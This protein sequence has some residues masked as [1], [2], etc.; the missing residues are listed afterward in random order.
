MVDDLI[1]NENRNESTNSRI[2]RANW[3]QLINKKKCEEVDGTAVLLLA[4]DTMWL[5]LVAVCM[6]SCVVGDLN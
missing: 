2:A 5:L 6:I 4:V 3:S 1:A